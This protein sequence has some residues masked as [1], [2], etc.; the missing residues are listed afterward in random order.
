MKIECRA[1]LLWPAGWSRT[2]KTRAS[3]FK[4]TNV[5]IELEKLR[6]ELS[7]IALEG[8]VPVVSA[9]LPAGKSGQ[10]LPA[11][12]KDDDQGVAIYWTAAN[13]HPQCLAADSYDS[14]IDNLHALVLSLEA[15]RSLGRWGVSQVMERV[16]TAFDSLPAPGDWR[17]I[18]GDCKTQAEVSARYRELAKTSHPDAPGGSHDAMTRLNAAFDAAKQEIAW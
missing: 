9:D 8:S 2:D 16:Y 4:D 11:Y 15:I 1:P 10:F 14:P 5:T 17:S 7:Y 13:G 6:R 18:L 3:L 12:R